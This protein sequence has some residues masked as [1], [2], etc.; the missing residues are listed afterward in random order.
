[1]LLKR[2]LKFVN[3]I[4]K[5][6]K[7]SL[8]FLLSVVSRDARSLIGSIMRSIL[9]NTGVQ[10][11]PGVTRVGEFKVKN[12]V[13][14]PAGDEWKVP[15]IFSL[16]AIKAEELVLPFDEPDDVELVDDIFQFVCTN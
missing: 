1:M 8:K 11:L 2:F 15:L 3:S 13:N 16:L 10:V 6:S 14:T 5:S 9:L 12:L 4:T 7:P